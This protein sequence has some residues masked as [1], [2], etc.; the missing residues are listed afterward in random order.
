MWW[1]GGQGGQQCLGNLFYCSCFP[2]K[3]L[4]YQ[5][6]FLYTL[7][8][9]V[10]GSVM[11]MTN[12]SENCSEWIKY[13]KDFL[14]HLHKITGDLSMQRGK[15]HAQQLWIKARYTLTGGD[16]PDNLLFNLLFNNSYFNTQIP[17]LFSLKTSSAFPKPAILIHPRS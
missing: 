16:H 12:S 17:C 4:S 2:C 8:S 6:A 13:M 7:G 1:E 15:P 10:P 11:A 9:S 3:T 14:T 5:P